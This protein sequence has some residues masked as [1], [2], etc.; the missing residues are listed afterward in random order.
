MYTV[1]I[2]IYFIYFIFNLCNQYIR[3]YQQE[4]LSDLQGFPFRKRY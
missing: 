2:F 3:I 4:K 1:L